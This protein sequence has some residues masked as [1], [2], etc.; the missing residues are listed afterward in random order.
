MNFMGKQKDLKTSVKTNNHDCIVCYN[1]GSYKLLIKCN[2][3]GNHAF[4]YCPYC[5]IALYPYTK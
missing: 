4:I 5:N 3:V 1:C 2:K